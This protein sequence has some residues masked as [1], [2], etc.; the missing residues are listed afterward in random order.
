MFKGV[1]DKVEDI[2]YMK[3]NKAMGFSGTK[4]ELKEQ[5]VASRK[6]KEE[7]LRNEEQYQKMK[8]T[9]AS[10]EEIAKA[11]PSLS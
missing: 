1:R 5:A 2:D 11:N 10:D 9:G 8:K 6:K 7:L 3:R 4:K